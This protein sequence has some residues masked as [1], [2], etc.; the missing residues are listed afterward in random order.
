MSIEGVR[1]QIANTCNRTTAMHQSTYPRSATR[2]SGVCKG[3]WKCML[4]APRSGN[5][6]A[7]RAK[8]VRRRMGK[9]HEQR[10]FMRE[11]YRLDR[12]DRASEQ[13]EASTLL[14]V[15]EAKSGRVGLVGLLEPHEIRSP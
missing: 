13:V 6:Y 8:A 10:A 2:Y 11:Q 15:R 3:G 14:H 1:R 4:C 5:K 7:S 12:G 9:R